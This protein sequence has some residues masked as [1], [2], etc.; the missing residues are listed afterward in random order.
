MR[1]QTQ[2]ISGDKQML[3]SIQ[4]VALFGI[5][6]ALVFTV[7]A[8]VEGGPFRRRRSYRSGSNYNYSTNYNR[9]GT[10]SAGVNASV[11]GVRVTAPGVGV[12]A[13]VGRG[14]VGATVNAPGVDVDAGVGR[15]GARLDGGASVTTP[16]ANVRVGTDANANLP[17]T[18]INAGTD[19]NIRVRGQSPDRLDVSP[20][21]ELNTPNSAPIT[22]PA[23]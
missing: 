4:K 10:Y 5:A 17:G 3:K 14:G 20:G 21:A 16:G 2:F 13:D 8:D 22:P 15:P 12:N 11:P 7:V 9:A 6:G 19:A 23:P 1:A 18:G